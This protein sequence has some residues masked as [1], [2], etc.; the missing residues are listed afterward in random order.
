[1][2][3]GGAGLKIGIFL[4]IGSI[5]SALIISKPWVTIQHAEPITVKGYADC[6]VHSDR[7]GLTIRVEE[8]N[9]SRSS[10]YNQIVKSI[11]VI[12]NMVGLALGKE[13][14]I[15]DL[16]VQFSETQKL[17]DQG[18]RTNEVENYR[19]S[20]KIRIDTSNVEGLNKLTATLLDLNA[21]GYVLALDGPEFFVADLEKIK[22]QLIE[23]ATAN[24]KNRAQKMAKNAGEKLGK[25][26]SAKQGVIQITKPNSTSTSSYGIYD[27]ETIK[28]SVKMVVSLDF[29]IAN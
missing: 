1:M 22:I 6:L 14:E 2:N 13:V 28:K 24:G 15:L 18:K 17:N 23:Q 10:A 16:G 11:E 7:G 4:L 26:V 9:A 3:K 20:K 27:L 8:S 25:L 5:G 12:K 29:E 21:Q 19:V